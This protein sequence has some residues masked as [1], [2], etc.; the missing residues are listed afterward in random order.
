[1]KKPKNILVTGGAGFIGS[2]F[3]TL[4]LQHGHKVT[5]IDKITYSGNT[6]TL[7]LFANN[8]SFNFWH[9]GIENTEKLDKHFSE[10]SA[11]E[12]FDAV[13]NFAAETHVDRSIE[14]PVMFVETNVLATQR[15]ITSLMR[16]DALSDGFRFL[17]VSTDEVFGSIYKGTFT[18]KTPYNPNSPYAASKASADHFLRA[19]FKT[20][21]FPV[22][23]SNC[24]NNYG[25]YQHPEKLVPLCILSALNEKTIPIYGDGKQMRDWLFVGDHCIALLKIL[26]RGQLGESYLVGTGEPI[27]NLALVQ[28]I[29]KELDLLYPRKFGKSYAELIVHTEDRPGHD[30]RYAVNPRKI[31]DELDWRSNINIGE[32]I[33]RTINWYLQNRSWWE[34]LIVKDAALDRKGLALVQSKSGNPADA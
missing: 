2:N 11:S 15:F 22:L 4:C 7:E 18:E 10:V 33:R 19:A 21:N 8:G 27:E 23:I 20:Y 29:C 30:K 24:S 13:V 26:M 12:K 31:R 9:F 25:P 16:T 17:H 34:P 32:G 14:N 1:M 3:V 5:V 6:D 28:L